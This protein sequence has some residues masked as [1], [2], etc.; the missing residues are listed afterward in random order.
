MLSH[1]SRKHPGQPEIS[2]NNPSSI[3]NVPQVIEDEFFSYTLQVREA[4]TDKEVDDHLL[5]YSDTGDLSS[6]WRRE[7]R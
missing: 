6:P 7:R 3:V 5:H 1:L 4:S 2:S